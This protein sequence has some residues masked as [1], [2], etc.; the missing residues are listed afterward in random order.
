MYAEYVIN[1][2]LYA[3]MCVQIGGTIMTISTIAKRISDTPQM[4]KHLLKYEQNFIK[5]LFPPTTFIDNIMINKQGIY[6]L[7]KINDAHK[8][9]NIISKYI[10]IS[11]STLLDATA[12]IGGFILNMHTHFKFIYGYE[13]DKTQYTLLQHNCDIYG[14]TNVKLFNENYMQNINKNKADVILVDPPWGGL[15]YKNHSVLNIELGEYEMNELIDMIQC[16]IILFKLPSNH[17]TTIFKPYKHYIYTIG[18]YIVVVIKKMN[19]L[20][21]DNN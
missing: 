11:K 14:I 20:M 4:I 10:D 1:K 18:N 5:T 7:T 9:T 3:H 16:K 13:I 6:S 8:I 2:Q 21:I 19:I 12:G 17:N 15:D